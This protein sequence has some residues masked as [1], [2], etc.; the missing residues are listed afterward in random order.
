MVDPPIHDANEHVC[1]QHF[2]DI[3]FV[4][5]VLE[6]HGLSQCTLKPDAVPIVFCF[7]IAPLSEARKAKAQHCAIVN[8]LLAP[9]KDTTVL[10]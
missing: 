5:P 10:T 8:E 2:N 4:S 3:D 6:G 1:S 7:N 9:A